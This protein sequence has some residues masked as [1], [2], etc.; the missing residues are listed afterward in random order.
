ME[1]Y[2]E[3]SREIPIR[4][5]ADVVVVGGGVAGVSAAI[6]AARAGADTLLIERY[7][8]LGGNLTIGLLEASMSFH[9][10]KG[11]QLIGG[12]PDEIM[13][14]L[15]AAGG[16]VGHVEDDV[17]YCGTVTP[18]DPEELKMVCVEMA[19]QAGVRLLLHTWVVQAVVEERRL[20]G[21]LIENKSGRQAVWGQIFVDCSGDAD[22]A[23]LAGAEF[24]QGREHDGRTQPMSI[25]FKVGNVD[26]DAVIS[27]VERCP[28]DFRL[29][30]AP[31]DLRLSPA[32]HLW[33]F[34]RI[35][36]AGFASGVLPFQ[37]SEMHVLILPERREAIINATRMAGDGTRT[38]DLTRAEIELRSQVKALVKHLRAACPGFGRSYLMTTAMSVQVRETRRI[39]GEYTLTESDVVYG[40]AFSDAVVQN[41]F[42]IDLHM[43]EGKGMEGRLTETSHQIPYRCLVPKTRDG[44]LVAGRCVSATREALGAIRL[45]APAM[46]MG[47]AAGTAAALAV[48]TGCRPRDVDIGQLRAELRIG[49]A[50]LPD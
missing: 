7:G 35:L 12:I 16:S 34:G 27:Y 37:R 3:E 46:A 13:Q 5:R 11:K 45:T 31:R 41:D 2:R 1:T 14:R 39:V 24:L 18:Y 26:V 38:E 50:I 44:L 6:A 17:G 47:Q 49:G 15:K 19:R 48:R 29:G 8:A 43:P 23:A 20:V 22:V 42:P 30:K 40:T 25:L 21:V 9:D 33:G 10:R 28:D 32:I 36:E 4:H